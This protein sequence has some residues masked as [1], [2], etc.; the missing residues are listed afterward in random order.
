MEWWTSDES[1]T[2]H[3][4]VIRMSD[5]AHKVPA[6]TE[7]AFNCPH[8]DA[9]AH[10][11]WFPLLAARGGADQWTP[12][13][14]NSSIS[15]ASQRFVEDRGKS[16]LADDVLDGK[17]VLENHTITSS[18]QPIHNVWASRCSH[19]QELAVW[20]NK[21][22]VYPS[23]TLGIRP[24]Q[25]LPDDIK[26]IFEEARQV[27]PISARSAAALLRL[28]IERLCV[29]LGEKGKSLYDDIASL[30]KKGL[31][32]D[33]QKMLD[34]V[35]VTGNDAVHPGKLDEGDSKEDV[36]TLFKLVNFI[37]DQTIS[38]QQQID[39]LY[40]SLPENV[41]SGIERRDQDKSCK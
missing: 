6:V 15:K 14:Q 41:R 39:N 11:S 7:S 18:L 22:M 1:P 19:C 37:A 32:L 5:D 40:D 12:Y 34:Y 33:V 27:A 31:P 25:D 29:F 30:V 10:Q 16:N 21:K 28:C 3:G 26:S 36:N 8:C 24:N 4:W 13:E 9:F 17:A 35:R 38:K 2:D 23:A 20:V